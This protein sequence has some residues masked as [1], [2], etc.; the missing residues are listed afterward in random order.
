MFIYTRA[1]IN[2]TINALNNFRRMLNFLICVCP[3]L[4]Y[5][6]RIYANKGWLI[7]NIIL[8]ALYTISFGLVIFLEY[9]KP[10]RKYKKAIKKR[11]RLI[12]KYIHWIG[13]ITTLIFIMTI[14]F[15]VI[16]GTLGILFVLLFVILLLFFIFEIFLYLFIRLIK[17]RME[18]FKEAFDADI[19]L[20]NPLKNEKDAEKNT[21]NISCELKRVISRCGDTQ[22]EKNEKLK[23]KAKLFF[24][25]NIKEDK[26]A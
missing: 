14:F 15:G 2:D 1:V 12:K 4:Y 16:V 25:K 18:L 26:K 8:L 3:I 9:A 23:E 7:V 5:A 21:V 10:K 17:R 13:S 22:E 19:K 24:K 6:S 11:K 20:L